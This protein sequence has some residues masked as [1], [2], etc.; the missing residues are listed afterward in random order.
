[1]RG[2]YY[3]CD[4]NIWIEDIRHSQDFFKRCY[5]NSSNKTNKFS[6]KELEELQKHESWVWRISVEPIP[7]FI[8]TKHISIIQKHK[9]MH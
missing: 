2:A 6:S 3:W 4:L 9:Y 7:Y 5:K 8:F 1:M